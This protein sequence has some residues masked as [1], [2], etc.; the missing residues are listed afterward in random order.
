[1]KPIKGIFL[2]GLLYAGTA[3]SDM[4]DDSLKQADQWWEQTREYAD[5][6]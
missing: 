3:S 4:V 5:N 2:A 1:M 6:A